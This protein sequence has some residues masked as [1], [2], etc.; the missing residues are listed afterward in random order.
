MKMYQVFDNDAHQERALFKEHRDAWWYVMHHGRVTVEYTISG[1][2]PRSNLT[3][4]EVDV[5]E[6]N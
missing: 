3:I 6:R 2:A 4:R 1:K 5:D